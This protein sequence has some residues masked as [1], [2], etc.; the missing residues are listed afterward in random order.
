[1]T[2]HLYIYIYIYIYISSQCLKTVDVDDL[3]IEYMRNFI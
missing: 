1:M 3:C 2:D